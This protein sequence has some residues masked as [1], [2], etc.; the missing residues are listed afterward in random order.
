M[1]LRRKSEKLKFIFPITGLTGEILAIGHRISSA[2]W[3]ALGEH[4]LPP[5]SEHATP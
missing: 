4:S 3:G 1:R 2:K 5:I